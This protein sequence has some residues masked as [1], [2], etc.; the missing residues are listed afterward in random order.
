[1]NDGRFLV[2]LNRNLE[3]DRCQ[4]NLYVVLKNFYDFFVGGIL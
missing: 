4:S 2:N 3:V 1:M